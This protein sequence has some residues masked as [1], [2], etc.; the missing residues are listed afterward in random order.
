MMKDENKPGE[1]EI[2]D[3]GSAAEMGNQSEKVETE[4]MW[5]WRKTKKNTKKM[6]EVGGEMCMSQ[7]E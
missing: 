2:G 3:V 5:C 1:R 7:P 4:D 6:R